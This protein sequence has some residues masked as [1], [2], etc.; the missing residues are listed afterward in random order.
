M[1]I[2]TNRRTTE[3]LSCLR[4]HGVTGVM[5]YYAR[6]TR[7]P[8]KRL[9][10]DEAAAMVAAGLVIGVVSQSSGDRPSSFDRSEGIEDGAHARCYGAA[11]IGQPA[12]SAIY[13][14]V[15]YDADE[16][17]VADRIA[18]YFEG[19]RDSFT[20]TARL[21]D[22]RVGVYGS[23]FVCASILD[24]GLAQLAW[25]SLHAG[26]RGHAAFKASDRW[27]LFQN[28]SS[29]LCGIGVDVDIVGP[30]VVDF[31]GFTRLDDAHAGPVPSRGE[32]ETP[33][34]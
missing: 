23:G 31:G 7:Q 6:S 5:R 20:R 10:R 1:L 14:A 29:T 25:L 15:D 32:G 18:P 34:R 11:V 17:D 30:G 8:E 16:A 4:A 33:G 12:G 13:F 28:P 24:R 21:P 9:T 27:T 3:R 19:I 26:H 2:D 22:Y